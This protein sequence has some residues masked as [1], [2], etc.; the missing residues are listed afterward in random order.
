MEYDTHGN[1]KASSTSDILLNITISSSFTCWLSLRKGKTPMSVNTATWMTDLNSIIGDR[2]LHEICLPGAHHAGMSHLSHSAISAT[3]LNSRRQYANIAAQL[4]AGS[5]VLDIRPFVWSDGQYYCGH[6]GE[7]QGEWLGAVG[8]RLDDAFRSIM[9]FAKANPG[10]LI[11]VM[12]SRYG[13]RGS[14]L[15][16]WNWLTFGPKEKIELIARVKAQLGPRLVTEPD[17]AVNLAEASLNRLI[18]NDRN[19]LCVFND[20]LGLTDPRTGLFGSSDGNRIA[21]IPTMG[22][23]AATR[24]PTSTWVYALHCRATIRMRLARQS[25]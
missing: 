23:P 2:R 5:R 24:D 11:I 1:I 8:E 12:F 16:N 17:P 14:A 4:Q 22:A 20:F 21:T 7:I 6:G 15:S 10:E 25:G 19:I 3:D 13:M 18:R 9:A